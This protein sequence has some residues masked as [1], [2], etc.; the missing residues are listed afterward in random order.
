[1]GGCLSGGQVAGPL[2]GAETP[3]CSLPC[4]V[5]LTDNPWWDQDASVAVSRTDTSNVL[6]MHRERRMAAAAPL[7]TPLLSETAPGWMVSAASA[8]SDGGRTW[9]YAPLKHAGTAAPGSMWGTF[10]LVGGSPAGFG[11]DGR[12]YMGGAGFDCTYT[13]T[14]SFI[15]ISED[16]GRTWSEPLVTSSSTAADPTSSG[17][18]AT[19]DPLTGSI[20][21]AGGWYDEDARGVVAAVSR[22]HGRTWTTSTVTE[23]PAADGY[24]QYV[25]PAW[26]AGGRLHIAYASGAGGGYAFGDAELEIRVASSSDPFNRDEPWRVFEVATARPAWREDL[27]WIQDVYPVVDVDRSGGPHDGRVYLSY[28]DAPAGDDDVIL[29]W[30]DDAGATWSE[31]M[32]LNDDL[33]GNGADQFHHWMAVDDSGLVWASFFDRRDDPANYN[34]TTTLARFDASTNELA[35]WRMTKPRDPGWCLNNPGPN[36]SETRE[37]CWTHKDGMDASGGTVVAAWTQG[38]PLKPDQ[39][40]WSAGHAGDRDRDVFVAVVRIP[41]G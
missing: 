35:N 30:S 21:S 37:N 5:Q 15:A 7:G 2:V 36:G 28:I 8:S 3:L 13:V 18:G 14:T 34:L 4:D 31:P 39:E 6:V 32:R 1:M 26:G 17:G 27:R 16:G 25:I 10:C 9:D 19:V 40:A 22:D 20:A 11:P 24:L 38:T 12:V 29:V 41:R 23:Q 33:V